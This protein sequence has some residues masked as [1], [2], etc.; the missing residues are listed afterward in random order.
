MIQIRIN[1]SMYSN[2]NKSYT[3]IRTTRKERERGKQGINPKRDTYFD[4]E[5][6]PIV[7]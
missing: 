1:L 2:I 6:F 7:S 5:L 3:K 4:E